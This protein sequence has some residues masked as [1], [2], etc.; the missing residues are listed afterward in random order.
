AMQ[1]VVS[2]VLG[3]GYELSWTGSA[4]FETRAG[5]LAMLAIGFGLVMVLLVLAALYE[6]ISL[7]LSVLSAVP[8]ALFGG[9]LA[10]WLRGIEQSIYFQVGVLVLIGLAAKNAILIV[11]FAVLERETGKPYREAALNA[12][13]LRFRPIIMTSLAFILGVTPL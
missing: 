3:D 10:V 4:Y 7:P 12:V 6:R 5:A 2:N 13:R 1:D 11:E 9:F 8:F